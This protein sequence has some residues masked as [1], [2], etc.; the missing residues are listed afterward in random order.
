MDWQEGDLELAGTRLHYYRRGRGRPLVVAHGFGD[1]G[2]CWTHVAMALESDYDVV[3]Y[4]ARSHGFSDDAPPSADGPGADL[5]ALVGA[6]RLERP[7]LLGHSMG[8]GSVAAAVA[9]RSNLFACAVLEDPGWRTAEQAAA[10]RPPR[11]DFAGLTVEQ[12]TAEARERNPEWH[13]SE[14][15]PWAE[16]KLQLRS[17]GLPPANA[18]TWKE[19]VRK[20]AGIPVLLITG[21]T[22][23]GSI[24]AQETAAEAVRL[25]PTL[26]VV[27]IAGAGHNIRR[28]RFVPFIETVRT[29]LD[30]HR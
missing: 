15:Q 4:D 13:E 12:L 9:E 30:R 3:A 27:H 22:A 5:I 23:L 1:S 21:D 26:E 20:L 7:A 16:S 25:C 17:T 29:F 14:L 11:R 18:D 10:P 24:V 8:A 2:P 19:T 6:L 28:D